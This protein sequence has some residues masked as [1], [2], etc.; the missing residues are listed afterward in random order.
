MTLLTYLLIGVAALLTFVLP[1]LAGSLQALAGPD[2]AGSEMYYIFICA[3]RWLV[4]AVVLGVIVA[5]GGFA[6]VSR[7]TI[8]QWLAVFAVHGAVGVLSALALLSLRGGEGLVHVG[9]CVFSIAVPV[10]VMLYAVLVLAS[11]GV[12]MPSWARGLMVTVAAV[13][14]VGGILAV[15]I[16]DRT[17]LAARQQA[18]DSA[19]PAREARLRRL[20]ELEA[21][22]KD[23]PLVRW[24][25][26]L[27][28]PEEDVRESAVRSI[29]ARPTLVADLAALLQT[30]D[31]VAALR[32]MWLRMPEAPDELARPTRDSIAG[33]VEWS[34]GR[35]ATQD[36]ASR[37][38]IDDACEAAVALADHFRDSGV[39]FH[40][41]IGRLSSFLDEHPSDWTERGRSLLHGW[42]ND[43]PGTTP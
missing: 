15:E 38:S 18:E 2:R 39:D 30:D 32:Y 34:R 7:H 5:R 26:F 6:W 3:P 17:E 9:Y 28:E 43:H 4:L 23:A 21:L 19:R 41:A 16:T 42:L 11:P 24:L 33:L 22:P 37:P 40:P 27:D 14:L 13:T 20:A 25:A 1:S 12:P 8:F 29:A 36:P 35:P 31:R 10:I